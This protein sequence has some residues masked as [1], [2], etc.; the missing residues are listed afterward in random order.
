M[1][2]SGLSDRPF[3]LRKNEVSDGLHL[4]PINS[5]IHENLKMFHRSYGNSRCN[6]SV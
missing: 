4:V 5:D 2:W 1:D 3:F 6:A